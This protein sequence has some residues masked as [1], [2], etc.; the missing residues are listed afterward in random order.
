MI[1]RKIVAI[2]FF[3]RLSKFGFYFLVSFYEQKEGIYNPFIFRA[4]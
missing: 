1:P 3:S 2:E 4:L